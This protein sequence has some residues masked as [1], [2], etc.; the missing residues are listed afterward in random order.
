MKSRYI[1]RVNANTRLNGHVFFDCAMRIDLIN[2]HL[3]EIT[4]EKF[5][6]IALAI[7]YSSNRELSAL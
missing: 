4:K 3:I 5:H 1:F 7:T 6:A 2:F